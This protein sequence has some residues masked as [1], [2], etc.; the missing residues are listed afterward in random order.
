VYYPNIQSG[1]AIFI[2]GTAGA[3]L[4]F[5]EANKV[6]GSSLVQRGGGNSNNTIADNKLIRT[7]LMAVSGANLVMADGNAVVFDSAFSNA[8]DGNDARKLLNGG[9]NFGLTRS[10]QSLAVEAKGELNSTDTLFYQLSNVKQQA[11]RLVFI[12]QNLVTTGLT[13][14][15]VDGYLNSRTAVSLVDTNYVDISFTADALS[16]ASN[17]FMLVFKPAAGP[18]PVTMVSVSANRNADRSI[19]INWWV[20]NQLNIDH[21]EVERSGDGRS[22]TGILTV[23]AEG[24]NNGNSVRYSKTDLSPLA[25]DNYYRIKAVSISGRLQYSAIV[26]VAPLSFLNSISV[27]PNPVVDKQMTVRFDGV[28]KG[29]YQLELSNVVGQVLYQASVSVNSVSYAEMISLP[30]ATPSGSYQLRVLSAD[31][32]VRVQQVILK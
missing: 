1:Q 22:F 3:L 12:P 8:V 13:A 4:S 29:N 14:E 2:F 15:L 26:K 27:Y 16:R 11:Y 6:N 30:A 10:G 31:G 28:D 18:L 20:E 24:S 25:A 23:A 9:E 17:R 7:N 19:G 5:N 21:Y 32:T